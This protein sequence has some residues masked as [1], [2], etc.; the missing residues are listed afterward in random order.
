MSDIRIN[1][2]YN[3]PIIVFYHNDQDGY[4]SAILIEQ[5]YK[6]SGCNVYGRP[7]EYGEQYSL[8]SF[9]D[10]VTEV[11]SY[12]NKDS[13]NNPI[14]YIV[15]Y[16]IAPSKDMLEFNVWLKDQNI[17]LIWLDHHKSNIENL[18][19]SEIEGIQSTE[20]SGCGLT[21]KY[22]YDNQ[23]LPQ[24]V[25]MIND[26]DIMRKDSSYSFDQL[27]SIISYMDSISP[28][29]SYDNQLYQEYEHAIQEPTYIDTIYHNGMF[30]W[31][32]LKQLAERNTK[33]IIKTV[34]EDR[35]IA[36]LNTPIRGSWQFNWYKESCDIKVI[37]FVDSSG[38]Y[39][40]SF[41]SEEGGADCCE[42]AKLFK[43]GGHP[44]AAGC[45]TNYQIFSI[46]G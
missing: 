25:Q 32:Y 34:Y 2:K 3:N 28:N 46:I 39:N 30:I 35:N 21:Y 42:F 37:W 4:L 10:T 44:T 9:K 19:D 14:V 36:I 6:D 22:L 31:N 45:K 5:K 26:F 38:I 41:Y 16:T 33:N 8:K 24:I 11:L 27:M 15:D 7:V 12:T 18:I 43:G 13:I 29:C 40:Y 1:I 23:P 20:F 17:K